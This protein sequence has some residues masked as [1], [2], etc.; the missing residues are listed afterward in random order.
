M[1]EGGGGVGTEI[2]PADGVKLRD[3]IGEQLE[4]IQIYNADILTFVAPYMDLI[5]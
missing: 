5:T 3:I 1:C 2:G 4:S